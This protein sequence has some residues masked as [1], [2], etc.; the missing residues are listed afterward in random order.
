MWKAIEMVTLLKFNQSYRGIVIHKQPDPTGS[1]LRMN[2]N[3]SSDWVSNIPVPNNVDVLE[4]GSNGEFT[5]ISYGDQTGWIRTKYLTTT[6]STTALSFTPFKLTTYNILTG[7]LPWKGISPYEDETTGKPYAVWNTR[8]HLIVESL[9]DSEIVMLNET[10][11]AQLSYIQQQLGI[12]TV[13]RALKKGEHDG[14]AILVNTSK[15]NVLDA[16]QSVIFTKNT[17]VVVAV[18]LQNIESQKHLYLVSLHLKSGYDD[19]EERRCKEFR[20]AMQLVFK[21]FPESIDAP[22]VVAGDL[23]SDYLQDFSILIKT[24]LPEE[25]PMLRNAAAD[26]KGIGVNTPTYYFWHKSVFDY[27]LLSKHIELQNMQTQNVGKK[28][29]NELQGSDH[30]PVSSVLKIQ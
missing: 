22:L 9:R 30:F 27:I 4:Y 17:Q 15:W 3:T 24:M 13:S 11:D 5:L 26:A 7:G 18:H 23:N 21:R 14:S 12:S 16:F 19:M 20:K 1:L 10:T 28:A 6:K 29:P 2:P 25:F 8:K